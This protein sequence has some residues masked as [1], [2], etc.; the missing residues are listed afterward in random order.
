MTLAHDLDD[1]AVAQRSG[2]CSPRI[3]GVARWVLAT[4][5]LTAP[6]GGVERPG[7]KV[8]FARLI[9]R[10][11]RAF[12][13]AFGRRRLRRRSQAD[14]LPR[15]VTEQAQRAMYLATDYRRQLGSAMANV[16]CIAR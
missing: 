2:A 11:V 16:I 12:W 3:P 9:H 15:R 14:R 10:R 7:R 5:R 4:A 13:P 6:L 1:P 8:R